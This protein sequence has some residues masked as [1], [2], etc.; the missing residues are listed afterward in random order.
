MTSTTSVLLEV[1]NCC[2]CGIQFGVPK[3]YDSRLRKTGKSFYCPNGHS[4]SYTVGETEEQKLKK[5]LIAKQAEVD[6]IAR[7]RDDAQEEAARTE[8]RRIA[9][10]GQITKLKNRTIKGECPCCEKTFDDLRIHMLEVH[11]DF[12]GAADADDEPQP[13]RERDESP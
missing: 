10:K 6:R 3:D 13:R 7:A 2:T 5:Q 9:L 1:Q 12:G 11:P 4:Q 8:R